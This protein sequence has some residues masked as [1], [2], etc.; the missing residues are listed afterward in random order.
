PPQPPKAQQVL[1]ENPGVAPNEGPLSQRAGDE[2][3][4]AHAETPRSQGV[5]SRIS[6]L[7]TLCCIGR[8]PGEV[9]PWDWTSTIDQSASRL[10]SE[11]PQADENSPPSQGETAEK[12]LGVDVSP[13]F[14][15]R[16]LCLDCPA[17]AKFGLFQQ[18]QGGVRG[19]LRS[20]TSSMSHPTVKRSRRIVQII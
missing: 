8:R 9:G 12:V 11:R 17:P 14:S 19:G 3:G 4:I 2:K 10:Q 1:E 13:Y 20:R 15:I 18:S 6:R 7:P 16:K 5:F